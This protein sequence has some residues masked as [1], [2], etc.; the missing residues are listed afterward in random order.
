MFVTIERAAKSV[1][2]NGTEPNSFIWWWI[3]RWI[4][5]LYENWLF[6]IQWQPHTPVTLT[7]SVLNW[8]AW[9][10]RDAT[11]NR[12][13]D[14]YKLI[15]MCFFMPRSWFRLLN[16]S[17]HRDVALV[18]AIATVDI[19]VI[20]SFFVCHFLSLSINLFVSVAIRIVEHHTKKREWWKNMP[21]WSPR[22]K[23]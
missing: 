18:I 21:D 16:L 2:V 3:W 6:H 17:S 15:M 23:K 13:T 7:R 20:H 4:S 14:C 10:K 12:L 11:A 1:R 19:R 9:L 22:K 8:P 5:I